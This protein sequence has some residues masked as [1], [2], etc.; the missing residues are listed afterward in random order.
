[1]SD[2]LSLVNSDVDRTFELLG[3]NIK[4]NGELETTMKPFSMAMNNFCAE[5]T[6][7]FVQDGLAT[8]E[9]SAPSTAEYQ[10]DKVYRMRLNFENRGT[11]MYDRHSAF[12]PPVT[13]GVFKT[14]YQH[15][16]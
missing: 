15:Q 11:M 13:K 14:F 4:V 2:H 7:L 8:F 12:G 10:K 3:G 1:M 5:T 16:L 6:D 9:A